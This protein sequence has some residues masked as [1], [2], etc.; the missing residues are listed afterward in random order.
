MDYS[1]S[2]LVFVIDKNPIHN[3]LVKY[4]LNVNRFFN[5]HSFPTGN[6]CLYKLGKQVIPDFIVTDYDTGE[7][8]GFDFLKKIQEVS[9]RIKTIFFS[10]YDDP[11]LAVRLLD[12]GATDY[13][14]KT[15]R[16]EI[17]IRELVKNMKFL[18]RE[19][20]HL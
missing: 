1:K 8:P 2:L 5:V 13:I 19:E 3:S 15:N 6:E 17:G 10:F 14:V 16:L 11:I 7:M 4:H 18:I 9:P 20:V 12:A